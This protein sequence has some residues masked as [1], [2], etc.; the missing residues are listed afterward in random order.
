MKPGRIL[1]LHKDY[2]LQ[3]FIRRRIACRPDWELTIMRANGS[4][5]GDWFV[6]SIEDNGHMCR[7]FVLAER[8]I[9]PL[10]W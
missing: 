6:A 2:A 3:G 7:R 4:S 1:L 5:A 10:P 8:L 9:A